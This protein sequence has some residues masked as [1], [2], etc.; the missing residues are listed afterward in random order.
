MVY[1]LDPTRES[2]CRCC[3]VVLNTEP[4]EWGGEDDMLAA[5]A[6]GYTCLAD[7]E[8]VLEVYFIAYAYGIFR[9]QEY[10]TQNGNDTVATCP[11]G[12]KSWM[13][14]PSPPSPPL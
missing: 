2:E 8:V 3:C 11:G 7:A 12:P 4:A 14:G 10:R 5:V 6:L 9:V 13:G 1:Q